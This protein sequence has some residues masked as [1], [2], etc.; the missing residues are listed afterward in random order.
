MKTLVAYFSASG[1]TASLAKRVAEAAKADLFEIKPVEPYTDADLKWT[2]PLARCNK[3]KIGKKRIFCIIAAVL[4]M[5]FVSEPGN[6][7]FDGASQLPGVLLGLGAAA[8]YATVVLFNKKNADVPPFE[9]TVVQLGSA[10]AVL[11]P[12][13]AI[14]GGFSF[15]EVKPAAFLL[16]AAVGIIHTGLAYVLYFGSIGALSAQTTALLSYIDPAVAVILSF[17]ILGEELS[18]LGS[19][20]AVLIIGS[21]IIGEKE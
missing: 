14:T 12:Y 9:K 8:L 20:G 13:T 4:G 3:E 7:G 11:L 1:N 10:A 2:N 6:I 15:A 16:L 18:A 21:A 19:I 17:A 5:V